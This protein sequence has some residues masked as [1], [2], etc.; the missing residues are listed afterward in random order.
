VTRAFVAMSGGV[1]SSVA[2]A[3]L[4]EEGYEVTGVT[5]QLWPSTDDEGGCCSVNAVRDAKRVCDLLGIPHYALNFRREFE[6]WVVRPY[7]DDYADGRT[8][9]PCVACNDRLKFADL[10][11][12]VMTQGADFLA[13]GHY[14]RVVEAETDRRFLG[15]AVDRSKDQSYFLY[16]L[17]PTQMAHVRFPLGTLH[18]RDVRALAA[19]LGLHVHDKPESQD[20]CFAPSGHNAV[21]RER[22]ADAFVPGPIVDSTGDTVGEHRGLGNY[23][24]GQRHGLGLSALAGPLYVT[25]IDP[26]R[27]TLVVGPHERLAVDDIEASEAVW[28]GAEEG[29]EVSVQTRYRMNA[30]PGR[31]HMRDDR[32]FVKLDE[33]AYGV[34]PGQAVVCYSHDLVLGGGTI[35]LTR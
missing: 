31:A 1:D 13:T 14:A 17:T 6:Q 2:A 8:P 27:N 11:S 24:V 23:T 28:Y 10:L 35:E 3:L 19:R 9:N 26:E 16:R 15:R 20:V 22:R 21:V 7:A 32:L 4:V 12:R 34:S 5:M 30:L 33:P 25:A 18:K 29:S